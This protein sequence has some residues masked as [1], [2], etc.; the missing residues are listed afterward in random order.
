MVIFLLHMLALHGV[1]VQ[2]SKDVYGQGA[3][4]KMQRPVK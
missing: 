2:M 3:F 1:Q 4:L